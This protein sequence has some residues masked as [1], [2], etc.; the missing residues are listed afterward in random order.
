M[1]VRLS[2]VMIHTSP[3]TSNAER[4]AQGVVGELI[5]MNGIDLTLVG[6]LDSLGESS[7]D[8][9]T[10]AS[11]SGDLAVLDWQQHE[12]LETAL[13]R[14]EI[15]GQRTVHVADPGA[16][17]S[18]R[19]AIKAAEGTDL[20]YRKLY[21]FNLN[22]FSRPED[23]VAS[24]VE[25]NSVRSV[26][27][28]KL[29]LAPKPIAAASPQGDDVA[30]PPAAP[31]RSSLPIEMDPSP[32]QVAGSLREG[33]GGP[34]VGA[35]DANREETDASRESGEARHAAAEFDLDALIDQLDQLD[36]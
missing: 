32:N 2:V 25:L 33:S 10:L 36:P 13:G 27:T 29:D 24:L 22:D 35:S 15:S 5:G 7:T 14:L 9:L 20:Q 26:R 8:R 17:D 11:I 31:R 16:T 3:A 19:S 18:G 1:A 6:P 30:E 4:V 23:V 12:A 21:L 28:F 34:S